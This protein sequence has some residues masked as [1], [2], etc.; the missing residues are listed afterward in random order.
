MVNPYGI[1]AVTLPIEQFHKLGSTG[2]YRENIGELKTI[3]DFVAHASFN[4]PYLLAY[5]R[6]SHFG[7]R[8][9]RPP[10]TASPPEPFPT[11][12]LHCRSLPGLAS[13]TQ[14]RLIRPRRRLR[15][16]VEPR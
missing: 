1:K 7:H 11:A 15:D 4:N 2:I 12:A 3:G 9:L 10:S 13:H 6:R 16:G 14:Q 8:Q 5:F